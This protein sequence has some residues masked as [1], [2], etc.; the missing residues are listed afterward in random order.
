MPDTAQIAKGQTAKASVRSG[1]QQDRIQIVRSPGGVEC[2]LIEEYS[3]PLI[4]LELSFAGGAAQDPAGKSGLVKLMASLL[5]EGAGDMDSTAFQE[6]LDDHAIQLRFSS[7]RDEI[8]GSLKTLVR[9]ADEAFRLLGL[10]MTEPRFD[11]DAVERVKAQIISGLR[12]RQND[13][14]AVSSKAWFATAFPNHPYGRTDEG[15]EAEV[16]KLNAKDVRAC[17]N[18]LFA[19]SNMKV[20]VVGAISA[21]ELAPKLDSMF[22]KLS[23]AA[24]LAVIPEVVPQGLGKRII[25]PLDLPQSTVRFGMAGLLRKDPDFIAATVVNHILGGGSFTSRIWQ[26]VREKRGLAYSVSAGLYPYRSAG[27]FFGGTATKN[28]RVKEAIE[29]IE[30][31]IALMAEKG[32]TRDELKKAISYLTGSYALRF[33]TSTKIANQLTMI[34]VEEL[35]IDYIDKRNADFERV[36]LADVKRVARRLLAPGALLVTIAGNPQGL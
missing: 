35:G 34:Q 10:A 1:S 15:A 32:P 2:W 5:D 36:K 20:S 9:H 26:E 27:L 29:V 12:R 25:L 21:S 3:V 14:N 30:A 24:E 4:A 31:E 18:R 28:E 19:R 13:P 16:A 11:T 33:D 7:G 6:R 8:S 17:W 22:G 23:A